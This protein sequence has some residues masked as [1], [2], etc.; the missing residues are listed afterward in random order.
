M[1]IAHVIP[2]TNAIATTSNTSL[3][4]MSCSSGCTRLCL[5]QILQLAINLNE[6][7]QEMTE[8]R[9]AVASDTD[10]AEE[11][12]KPAVKRPLQ[13]IPDC[14]CARQHGKD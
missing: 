12:G 10:D 6:M 5:N 7:R 4:Q 14:L 11:P 8:Y 1:T 13:L 9:G 3:R 2:K